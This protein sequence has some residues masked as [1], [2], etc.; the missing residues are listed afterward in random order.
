MNRRKINKLR[1]ELAAFRRSPQDARA[2]E[3]LATQLGRTRIDRGKEPVWKSKFGNLRVVSIPHHGG[4]DIP[5]GTKN[6]I[7][8]QLEEDLDAWEEWLEQGDN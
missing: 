4:R 7:L 5:V 3:N 2:L 1:Q 8:A 6:S